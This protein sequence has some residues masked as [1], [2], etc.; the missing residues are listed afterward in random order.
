[1][2]QDAQASALNFSFFFSSN[3]SELRFA[4]TLPYT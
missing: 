1:M 2:V 3:A 4:L